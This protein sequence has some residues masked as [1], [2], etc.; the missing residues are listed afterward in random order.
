[1]NIVKINGKKHSAW[2]TR[3]EADKQKAVLRDVGY[4]HISSEYDETVQCENG[5]YYV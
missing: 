1:M 4:R 3:A 2:N 5:H